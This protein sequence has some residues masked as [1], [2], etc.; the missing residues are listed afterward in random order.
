[1]QS[2]CYEFD[3]YVVK[4]FQLILSHECFLKAWYTNVGW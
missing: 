3:N 2:T 1:M 4:P